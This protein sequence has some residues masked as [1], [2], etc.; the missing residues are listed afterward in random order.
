MVKSTGSA[1]RTKENGQ[2]ALS[3]KAK[4]ILVGLV[5]AIIGS[6]ISGSYAKATLTNYTGF[7][8][9][10]TGIAVFVFWY[11]CNGY[12]NGRNSL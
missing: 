3:G 7:G 10:L 4:L 11:V 9:L 6:V 5:L 2:Q 1:A 12:C 8:M